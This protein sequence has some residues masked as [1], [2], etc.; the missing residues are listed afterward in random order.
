MIKLELHRNYAN[1]AYAYKRLI[2]PHDIYC[3]VK[4]EIRP[5]CGNRKVKM[6]IWN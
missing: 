1:R 6:P 4:Q 5:R 2:D 3:W